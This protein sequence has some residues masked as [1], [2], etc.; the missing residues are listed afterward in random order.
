[1]IGNAAEWCQDP[2]P[3]HGTERMIL[4]G[5]QKHPSIDDALREAFES[6]EASARYSEVG[7]RLVLQFEPV[8][9][10]PHDSGKGQR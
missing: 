9:Q 7:F 5:S 4:G 10:S 6:R 1:M 8:E 2:V 3:N